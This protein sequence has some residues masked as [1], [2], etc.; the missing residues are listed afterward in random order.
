MNAGEILR[1]F[2]WRTV[3]RMSSK[4]GSKASRRGLELL[5]SNLT[6]DQ[7]HDFLTYRR[8]D[9]VG[10]VT[11]RTYRIRF[12][13]TMNVKELHPDGGC[14]RRL[15]FFPEGQLVDGDVVLAQK[16][17]LESF[18]LETLKIANKLPLGAHD[19]VH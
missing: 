15:C 8:F 2:W 4:G 14:V 5:R 1:Q 3:L 13:G 10:G 9:V 19:E 18:E 11:G 7:L 6:A 12:G 16:V 17:A